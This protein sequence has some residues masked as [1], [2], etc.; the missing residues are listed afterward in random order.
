[1]K[2]NLFRQAF[3]WQSGVVDIAVVSMF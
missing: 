1:V 3:F 2:E